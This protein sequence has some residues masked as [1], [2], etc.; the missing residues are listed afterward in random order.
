MTCA[1]E[2]KQTEMKAIDAE[3]PAN[4]LRLLFGKHIT[5]SLS[6]VARLGVAD[7][8]DGRPV[9]V[10][11]LAAKV[12]AHAA[13]LYRVMRMLATVGVFEEHENQSFSHTALSELLT[14]DAPG[15]LRYL[16]TFWGDSW[17]TRAFE[18]ITHTLC[19]GE[20]GVTKAYGK[21]A[22]EVL[23]DE[24]AQAETFHRGMVNVSAMVGDAVAKAYDFSGFT[25]IADIG[26]GHGML[27]ASILHNYPYLKGMLYDLPEVVAGAPQAECLSGIE[28]RIQIEAGSFFQR[29]PGGCDAY[30]LKNII[31]DWS[32]NDC[33]IILKL[34]REQLPPHGRVLL[35][36]M[37]VPDEH[38]RPALAK[39]F[40][41]EMLVVTPGGK[42][43]TATEFSHLFR[44]AG[45]ELRR[46]IPTESP[47]CVL[48]AGIGS[49]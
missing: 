33:R 14:T 38:S 45:L 7:H 24:P 6:A 42:E 34:I 26:G 37:V 28:N 5:Y 10:T 19:T 46:I 49:L 27:L 1:Q 48:E 47:L 3:A 8:I 30:V 11:E 4:L 32:D 9:P 40:D 13:S 22:F 36:E 21:H 20:D 2:T 29:V 15:S 12:G 43:R 23:A 41:V 44:S 16:A 17:S 31:H 39:M 18:N 25:R 35:C